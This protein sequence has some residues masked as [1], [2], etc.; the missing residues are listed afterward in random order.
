MIFK[1]ILYI[2]KNNSFNTTY[3]KIKYKSKF[4]DVCL[5]FI[6]FNL[7]KLGSV[8]LIFHHHPFHPSDLSLN[9]Y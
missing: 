8:H 9:Q 3:P 5:N 1:I 4:F 2:D 7:R 6:S